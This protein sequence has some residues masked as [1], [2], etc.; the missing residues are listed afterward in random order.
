MVPAKV[1][2]RALEAQPDELRTISLEPSYESCNRQTS[3]SAYG[4][5]R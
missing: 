4:A 1:Q 2:I 3:F 5:E